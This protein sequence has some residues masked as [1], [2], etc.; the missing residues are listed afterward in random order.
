MEN[1][2]IVCGYFFM[3]NVIVGKGTY[4][5]PHANLGKTTSSTRVVAKS[6]NTMLI[7]MIR[8][9]KRF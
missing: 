1:F 4:H 5:D 3:F 8:M 6:R 2:M 9:N 7:V